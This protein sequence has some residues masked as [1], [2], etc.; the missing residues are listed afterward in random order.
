MN[1]WYTSKEIKKILGI[2]S[3]HLYALKKSGK[4]EYKQVTKKKYLF[5][6][7]ETFASPE[8]SD[9]K[10]AIYARVSTT[11]QKRDLDNQINLLKQYAVATGN[12]VD[13]GFVFKDIA[14]GMNESRPGLSSLFDRILDRTVSEVIVSSK[15]R[16]TRFGFGYLESFAKRF[17]TEIVVVNAPENPQSFQEELANDLISIIHHFSMKFYGKRRSA[18]NALAKNLKSV[19][20]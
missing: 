12:V 5:R 13:D 10:I 11:K 16:L 1:N 2:T 18:L 6:L 8:T 20:E 15:D 7:P 3:Q 17:G 14:S 4:L 9:R 19:D